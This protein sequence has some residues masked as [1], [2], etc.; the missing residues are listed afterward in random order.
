MEYHQPR[1]SA[2]QQYYPLMTSGQ[3]IVEVEKGSSGFLTTHIT[4]VI[5]HGQDLKLCF[6]D[7]L[8]WPAD[9][10]ITAN[11]IL[12]VL[13]YIKEQFELSPPVLY[14]QMDNCFRD[15]KKIYIFGFCAILVMAGVFKK[16]RLS[17]L[18]V[19]HTH[20]D[21][22]QMFSRISSA[23]SKHSGTTLFRLHKVIHES[24]SPE[25]V[26]VDMAN[27]WDIKSWMTPCLP[28]LK[29]LH[30]R[31]HAFR[32]KRSTEGHVEMSYRTW[33]KSGRKEWKPSKPLRIL[34]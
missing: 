32:F 31:H 7:Q 3:F 8:K 15:C 34:D 27:I 14:L 10:N 23:L 26:T 30:S 29:H 25:P 20:E 21:V 13:K 6:I 11:V 28:R 5:A 1:R 18:M 9:S 16:V 4:G 17:Y 22:D 12:T 19:G 2:Q 33:S 24:F